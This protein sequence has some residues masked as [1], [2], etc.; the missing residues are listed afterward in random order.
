MNQSQYSMIMTDE[1]AA[2]HDQYVENY[3][4]TGVKKMIGKQRE[5]IARRKDGSTFPAALG[6]AEPQA[7]GLICGFIRD[8]T[9]EKAAQEEIIREQLLNSKIID[10]SFDGLFVIDQKGIIQRV[11][12]ASC[13]VFGW[14]QDEFI[15]QNIKMIMPDGHREN[16]DQYLSHYM[17]TGFKKM[18]GKE[19]EI[20]ARRRDGSTF[21]CILGLSE[22]SINGTT[23]FVGFIRDVTMEKS[24]LIA[25]AEREAS[26]SL[27][28]NILP[29][30]IARRLKEDP[31][32]I[33]DQYENTTILFA[34][35]G[36]LK[37]SSV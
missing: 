3:L 4:T 22:V 30:H 10:A 7:A 32:H 26:D 23:Q 15:G 2:H 28:F 24:L 21:P 19:R 35:I 1:V 17:K 20:E 5:V 9:Q 12:K 27:L 8:L 16:H 34:D 36:E 14:S 6:L 29:E 18:I 25:Q 37:S 13:R 31:G 33:A 11:N